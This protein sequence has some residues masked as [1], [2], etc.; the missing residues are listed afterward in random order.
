M[1]KK[2]AVFV[3]LAFSSSLWAQV[4]INFN[5]AQ[6]PEGSIAGGQFTGVSFLSSPGSLSLADPTLFYGSVNSGISNWA[7]NTDLT[8]TGTDLGIS[9]PGVGQVLHA[10]GQS[11]AY[12]GWQSENG[13]PNFVLTF[14]QPIS[15]ITIRF[16]GDSTGASGMAVFNAAAGTFTNGIRVAA[17]PAND[18]D[19]VTLSG[20][21]A[22]SILVVPGSFLDWAAV[23]DISYTVVPEPSVMAM[24]G[25]GALV[26]A[27]LVRRRVARARV[28]N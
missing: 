15:S 27:G 24:V 18:I 16:T 9:A 5:T 2:L 23:V 25:F 4:V 26:V 3:F 22:T 28:G 17:T 7:T 20:L 14:A 1:C 11:G 10:I 12:P 6:T 13:D 8:V 19:S 21:N